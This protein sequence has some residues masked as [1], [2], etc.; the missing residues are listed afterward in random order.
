MDTEVKTITFKG[1]D[2]YEAV[3]TLAAARGFLIVEVKYQSDSYGKSFKTHVPVV[4]ISNIDEEHEKWVDEPT[5][6]TLSGPFMK[7]VWVQCPKHTLEAIE[8][9]KDILH[10]PN[11]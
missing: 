6:F 7:D 11:N 4:A 10:A 3:C 8:W 9:I 5:S 2:D 1:N